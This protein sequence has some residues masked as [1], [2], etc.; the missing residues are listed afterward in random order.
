M[1]K[2]ISINL[3]GNACQVEESGYDALIAYLEAAQ[4]QLRDNPDRDEIVADLE[5]AIAEKCQRYLNAHKTVVAASEVDTII[6]E[7]GSVDGGGPSVAGDAASDKTRT[8]SATPR[9]LYRIADGAMIAGVCNGIGAYF[10]T[11]PTI[12]RVIFVGLLFLTKGGFALVYIVLAF[13]LPQANTSEERAAAHGEPFNAQ[14]LIDRAKKQYADK[15]NNWSQAWR[16]EQRAWRRRWRQNMRDRR[17]SMAGVYAPPPAA[18]GARIAA[19]L[20]VPLL[21]LMSIALFWLMLFAVFSLVTRQEL[22]GAV[23]PEDLPLWLGIVIVVVVYQAIAWPLHM[24]RRS[25][26]YMIGGAY[27]GTVAALDGLLSLAFVLVG[28]WLAFNYLPEVREFLQSLPDVVR[29]F[30]DSVT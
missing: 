11:D 24:L 3:N 21:T 17:W 4:R 15:T 13:V 16:R 18:Y 28:I 22:F 9:R 14:E 5:Q 30:R 23:L 1:Q 29:S 25:T 27:Y 19:G 26:Y 20:V 6:K 10:R 8:A 12:V 7:M 2:V